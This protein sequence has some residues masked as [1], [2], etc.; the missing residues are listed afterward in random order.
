MVFKFGK[1]KSSYNN[2]NIYNAQD[3]N[4]NDIN[5][6]LNIG[7]NQLPVKEKKI[8]NIQPSEVQDLIDA[9]DFY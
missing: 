4:A 3:L 2:Y 6:N 1:V 5:N 9:Q 8:N 7:H